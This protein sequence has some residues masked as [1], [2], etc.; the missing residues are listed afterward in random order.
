MSTRLTAEERRTEIVAAACLEFADAGYAGTSTDAIARRSGV[1]Q[2]YLFQLFG[3]K[4][5]LFLAAVRDCFERTGTTFE[6]SARAARETGLDPRGI[7]EEMGHA[8]VR[9]LLG[10][11]SILRLQLQGYAA[12]QDP[13]IRR[14]VRDE[15]GVLWQTVT[16]M[17]GADP[18]AVQIWFAQ[19][20]LIN[21]A[22]SISDAN[23]PDK[24]FRSLFGGEAVIC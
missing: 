1:S 8:Y 3:T 21:V 22:A 19:G 9:L 18:E 11:R 4:K 16:R 15:Y 23:D 5:E 2:P 7:L 10:D 17:S 14:V 6:R 12:C 20:M 24:F 13:D